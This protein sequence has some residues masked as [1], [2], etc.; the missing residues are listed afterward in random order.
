MKN[1]A[2][3]RRIIARHVAL[4]FHDFITK[5]FLPDIVLVVVA[6]FVISQYIRQHTAAKT[7]RFLK[8]ISSYET[9][10]R[11]FFV[12]FFSSQLSWN[13]CDTFTI[14]CQLDW[15]S[16]ALSI[17]PGAFPTADASYTRNPSFT[18]YEAQSRRCRFRI[19]VYPN[20][21]H[22][23]LPVSAH[24]FYLHKPYRRR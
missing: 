23:R 1:I 18:E 11:Q 21:T 5:A 24:P 20:G 4:P 14:P 12:F 2:I 17:N 7:Q 13:L 6:F 3:F 9:F 22:Q 15:E 16:H 10:Q 8:L 19:R